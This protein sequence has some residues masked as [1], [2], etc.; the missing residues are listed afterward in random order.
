MWTHSSNH[1][2]DQET[3]LAAPQQISSYLFSVTQLAFE[4]ADAH[5]TFPREPTATSLTSSK[6]LRK[7]HFT[8][9]YIL[10]RLI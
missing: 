5:R 9:A 4:P 1:H 6:S 2:T 3:V 7:S 8:V 10:N